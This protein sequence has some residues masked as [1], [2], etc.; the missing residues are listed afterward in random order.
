MAGT[1]Y[2][3][4]L[5]YINALW[6]FLRQFEEQFASLKLKNVP[7]SNSVILNVFLT[8]QV[9]VVFGLGIYF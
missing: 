3:H 2:F 5:A 6:R 8:P 4:K 9:V 1:D 7:F